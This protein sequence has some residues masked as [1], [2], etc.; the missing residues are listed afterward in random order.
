M[1]L[2][3]VKGITF[4]FLIGLGIL[5]NIYV[6][7]NYVCLF[8]GVKRKSSHLL[9]IHL[10]FTN[11][12]TLITGGMPSTI[13]SLGLRDLL[14]DVACKI[15]VYLSRVARGLSICT[16]CLLT[17]VQAITISP[18]ASRWGR[19][20]PRSAWHLLPLLVFLWIL[21]SLIS[22]N[23]PLYIKKSSSMNSS[24][25][26][27]NEN[28]CYF[29]Q[30]NSTIMWIF[31][32]LMVLR[33][34]VFQGVMGWASGHMVF[35]LHKHHQQVLYLQTSKLLH[36]TP[37]EVKAAKSV[38]LLMLCFLLFYWADCF[39]AL[40]VTFSVEK[41]FLEV[42]VLELVNLGYAVLS[43]FVLMHREG[44]LAECWPGH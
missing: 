20:Q 17:V 21:N 40:Y 7:V 11:S 4:M 35:L 15:V 31:I 27:T 13:T 30:Q 32:V 34:A 8:R 42:S 44:H 9:L 24:E 6:F 26:R 37:P 5:G 28:Y 23:L 33:D 10:A 12:I 3:L 18:R 36:R 22:M 2:P 43:P 16:T 25:I 38:L 19:L 39:M 1:V 14:G 29:L 41:R